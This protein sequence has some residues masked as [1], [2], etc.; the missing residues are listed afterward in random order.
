[1]NTPITYYGGKQRLAD[2]I[3][4]KFP[5]HKIYCE[6]YFGGGAV[7][8]KKNKSFLEVINDNNDFLIN[9]YNVTQ[10]NYDE[11]KKII[12]SSLHSESLYK[13]AKDIYN[14]KIDGNDIEKAWAFW[15]ITN[16]SFNGSMHGSWKWSNGKTGSHEG[17]YIDNK[18]NNFS[19]AVN[20]RLKNVQ[21]SC[22]DALTV[23][24]NRDT[25]DTLFYLDP[26]YPD[27]YQQHYRGFTH[28][29]L[30]ELLHVLTT[31]KGKFILSNY[32]SQTLKYFIIKNNWNFEKILTSTS[33]Q[34]LNHKGNNHSRIEIL[35]MNFD[36]NQQ[37]LF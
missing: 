27:T 35:C 18:K 8:F 20:E 37:T 26:P 33:C 11:L 10:N 17:I 24:M 30:Y 25:E 3:I 7:F 16:L 2:R 31:I 15:F 32:W 14:K 13:Y 1:M 22:R 4:A 34:N 23:I 29:D 19:I 28:K 36:T 5:D 9:F 12:D 6:P 21:I